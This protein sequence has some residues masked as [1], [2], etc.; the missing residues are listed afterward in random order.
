MMLKKIA[1]VLMMAPL[2]F[3]SV[4]AQ[5]NET[6]LGANYNHDPDLIELNLLERSGV[7][8]VRVTPRFYRYLN[9][10]L[11]PATDDGLQH[12]INAKNSGYKVA[13]GFRFDFR[14][15]NERIPE[16][17]SARENEMFNV[18]S[19]VL[20]RIGQH[21]DIFT[22]GNEPNLETL[23]EDM[24]HQ[25]SHNGIP[26][27]V[28]TERLLN[29]VFEPFYELRPSIA[30]P[31]VYGGSIPA[32]FET[33]WKNNDAV[34]GLLQM[35]NDDDRIAGFDLHFHISNF[36]EVDDGF[37]FA[38]S[39]MP[40][41]PFLITEFSLHRLYRSKI[42]EELGVDEAGESFAN[43]YGYD[44][45][46]KAYQWYTVVNSNRVTPEEFQAFFDSRSWYPEG[47]LNTYREK[48]NEYGV[49]LATYPILQ[50]SAPQVLNETSP[51]WFINPVFMQVSLLQEEDGALGANPLC[52]EDYLEWASYRPVVTANIGQIDDT[53]RIYPNPTSGLVKVDKG[54]MNGEVK[55]SIKD[56]SG[57][58]I[59]QMRTTDA[60]IQLD[61]SEL[62]QGVYI[63]TFIN[64][65]GVV[66]KKI[67]VI[68][69]STN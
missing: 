31:E 18:A 19:Q 48:F 10:E 29:E 24:I 23:A 21:I 15:N 59:Q 68:Q 47:Y 20:A 11:D 38:R 66:S 43:E 50:Q 12:L 53:I 26:L 13:F 51:L 67:N 25:E 2:M 27:V 3:L 65:T 42:S 61:V 7:A 28:F 32:I 44:P 56:L 41:K 1:I 36:D 60:L 64:G 40:D 46:W 62:P 49:Y 54:E 69:S 57:R 14:Q 58:I 63:I 17:G 55:V 34:K 4:K 30:R 39:I 8:W 45:T 9:G 33:R 5:E 16:P 37:Q 52:V 22:L 6:Q 35:A